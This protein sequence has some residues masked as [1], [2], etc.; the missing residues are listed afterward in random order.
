VAQPFR[1]VVNVDIRDSEPDWSPFA[2]ARAP[3]GAPNVVYVVLDDVGFSAMGC[4]GGPVE[5]P[6]IDRIAAQGVRYTQWHTTALC[7][8]TRSCLLTGRNHTRNSMA[9]ITEAAIGFPNASGTIPPENGML[10]EILGEAGWN[11]YMVGKWHL[12]PTDEMNLAATRR[13]WPSGRGFER[14]YGFLGA[15]TN[16]WYPDLVYD[17]HPVDQPRSPEEGYHLTED[18]TDKALEF[19][20]DAKAVAPE[21]P[22]FLYYAPGACHAPHHAPREWIERYRG[23]FDQGYEALREQT[24]ARQKTLGIVP[25]DTELPP[26]NPIG[27]SEDRTGPDGKPFPPLDFTR[28]WAS[29]SEDEQRLFARMAEVYAGFLSH[30]D[31]HIGRLLDYLEETGQLDNTLVILVSDNGASGEG[32]PDGSVNEMKFM[33]GIPD[34]LQQNLAM[35]EQLG[36]TKTYNHYPT[37]WAMAFNTP[38]KMW[39]RYEFNGGTS[40]PCIISWPAGTKAR[41][42]LRGQYHHAIDLVP[43][44]LDVL[45]VEPPET[46]KGH[47]QSRLDGVSMRY[48]FD[49]P[50][51]PSTRATQF[52]SMLGSRAIWHDGWK[53]VTTH[54][55]I[56]GWSNFN[57]DTWELYHT[58]VD[59]AELHDLAADHPDKL[60]ELINLWY[61][62]AGANQAFPLDDRS[63][64]E[65][66][67]TPRPQLSAPRN[68]YVYLPDTAEIPEAQAVN[69]RNRSYVV[70]AQVDLPGPGAQG[71]LF[72][73]GSR[74]G[75]HALYLKDNRLHYIYNFVGIVE[76]KIDATEDL[77]TGD[78]LI[79]SASFD[80]VGEDPPGVATGVLS[81]YHGDHKVGEGR[82][83]TQPG[84]FAIAGEGLCIGR[85]GGEPV[86]DDYPGAPP[87]RFTGGTLKRVAVDVSG[88]PYVDLEREA[89][90]LIMRE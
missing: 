6:N 8:P 70:A 56:S 32:G 28:P 49:D 18:I 13:N 25:A 65:I 10:P 33:N 7:S 73:H 4:Y 9:C 26:V 58:D 22:F 61:A 51:A 76:Q 2:A 83:K 41:D 47:V 35:L 39:K 5:T 67:I 20:R 77:P 88:E 84:G 21:K 14:W 12:C 27:T 68:R 46:I 44:I 15:E 54:P 64:L 71:V 36:G 24:L 3:D 72:A 38:F 40:D 87:W 30:A 90:A 42:E 89:A 23:R 75:G 53:A 34:D 63:A 66:L 86:T 17:N 19:I 79:L 55:A 31:H 11:T 74:F 69:V 1:G 85:D 57:D 29:L 80:K 16:Q 37:G 52:Y 82:I 43:T 78:D 60:R 50:A 62:E 48:S 81:L 45:G 59:R